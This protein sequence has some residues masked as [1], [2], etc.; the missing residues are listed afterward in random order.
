MD[1]AIG[2]LSGALATPVNPVVGLI[3]LAVIVVAVFIRSVGGRS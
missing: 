3:I 1:V 2:L